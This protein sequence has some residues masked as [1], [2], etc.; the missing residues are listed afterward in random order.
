MTK[1]LPPNIHSFE[2][3][4]DIVKERYQNFENFPFLVGVYGYSNNGKT[5]FVNSFFEKNFDIT[6][7]YAFRS[8]NGVE[9][10]YGLQKK[11]DLDLLFVQNAEVLNENS[12]LTDKILAKNVFGKGYNLIVLMFNNYLNPLSKDIISKYDLI[13][14]NQNSKVK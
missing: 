13:V 4:L 10:F 5:H 8:I 2:K 12:L 9:E 14:L 3:S 1:V 6:K 11:E 7:P